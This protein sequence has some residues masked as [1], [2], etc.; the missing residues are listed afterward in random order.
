M[1][2]SSAAALNKRRVVGALLLGV[3][4]ITALVL[5]PSRL[6]A[7]SSEIDV[8]VCGPVVPAAQLTISE[9]N[10]DSVVSR[11]V[12]T[13]RG[14]V[15]NTSQI[16]IT[17]DGQYDTSISIG[18]NVTTFQTD[19]TL[20]EGTHTILLT[21][22]AICGGQSA[23][24]AIV[25]TYQPAVEPSSG[26]TTPTVLEAET[27]QLEGVIIG[28]DPISQDETA[29]PLTELPIIGAAVNVVSDFATAIGLSSTVM[30][31]NT[32]TV[33]G[34]ARVGVTAVALA[35]VVLASSIAPIA[36]Q[37]IPGVSEVFTINSHRSMI[38]LGWV[39]RGLGLLAL[40]FAYFL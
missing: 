21:A 4:L 2:S 5:T 22:N 40:A 13:F 1:Q 26:S 31:G 33:V 24:Q 32:P 6:G 23:S 34:V 16:E 10:D 29:Q 9:P 35:S 36:V 27:E 25:L 7:V 17:I 28:D 30:S 8:A 38:Y 11:A 37:A 39:I 14:T 12:T 15:A 19:I 3:G 20:A 18:A